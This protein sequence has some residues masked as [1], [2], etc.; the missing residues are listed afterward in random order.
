MQN[1]QMTCRWCT[2][3]ERGC[4]KVSA[5][6]LLCNSRPQG[7]QTGSTFHTWPT[8][9]SRRAKHRS[10]FSSPERV[11]ESPDYRSPLTLKPI[12]TVPSNGT[13]QCCVTSATTVITHRSVTSSTITCQC[14]TYCH[15]T[16]KQQTNPLCVH[17]M[18]A[19][20]SFGCSMTHS[21]TNIY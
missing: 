14:F 13:S 1:I 17:T 5:A 8:V 21:I 3:L 12:L 4:D 18:K 6:Q 7:C 19:E 2:C 9:W 10:T 16:N 11:W 20:Q 15:T